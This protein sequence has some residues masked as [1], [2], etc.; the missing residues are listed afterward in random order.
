MAARQTATRPANLPATKTLAVVRDVHAANVRPATC[1]RPQPTASSTSQTQPP[2]QR[3]AAA[4]RTTTSR[5]LPQA[6]RDVPTPQL[7]RQLA[8][9]A[10]AAAK[11][12]ATACGVSWKFAESSAVAVQEIQFASVWR[13]SSD[14]AGWAILPAILQPAWKR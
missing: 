7:P 12:D 9:L 3:L 1:V 5:I 13:A 11:S 6:A 8:E 4:I 2:Q 14:A 10:K